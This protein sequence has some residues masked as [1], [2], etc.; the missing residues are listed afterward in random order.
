MP[1][2]MSAPVDSMRFVT[3]DD[4]VTVAY[5][6]G[7]PLDGL[8]R[9]ESL[10]SALALP[11]QPYYEYVFEKAAVLLRSMLKNHPFV[12]GNKRMGLATTALFLNQNGHDLA[13]DSEEMTSF[14][15]GVAASSGDWREF[16]PWLR[17]H[18]SP[19]ADEDADWL[20]A[21]LRD[22]LEMLRLA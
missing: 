2:T 11:R 12:D 21:N 18:S 5:G 4:I 6:I 8:V 17:R 20:T 22:A 19:L 3:M 7:V 10:E 13:A 14:V 9:T 16:E 1:A 15:K